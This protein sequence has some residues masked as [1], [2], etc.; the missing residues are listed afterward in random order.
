[1]TFAQ[2]TAQFSKFSGNKK[3]LTAADHS[4]TVAISKELLFSNI[5]SVRSYPKRSSVLPSVKVIPC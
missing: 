4:K 3:L 2:S 5:Y 1:M